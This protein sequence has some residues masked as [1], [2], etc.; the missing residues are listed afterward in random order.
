MKEHLV[1][2]RPRSLLVVW[3]LAR[4]VGR[5]RGRATRPPGRSRASSARATASPS[6]ASRSPST[7][8][9]ASVASTTGPD[10]TLPGRRARGRRVRRVGRRTRPRAA[11]ARDGHGRRRRAPARPR[12]RPG[13]RRR[14]RGRERHARRGDAL[15]A[16]RRAPTCSTASGSTTAPRPSL[17]PL[18]QEVPGVATARAGQT[19]LQALRVHPR[20]RV[21]LRVRARGRRAGQPAGRRLRL[22]HRAALRA[23]AGRGRARRGEQPLRQRRAGRRR[24][25][26]DAPRA[27]GRAP[28]APRRG[29]GRLLRLAALP[30]RD[31]GRA[32]RASTGTRAC[33]GS[34]TDN[35]EP[36]SRFEQ[37]AAALSA[38]REARRAHATLRAVVRFDDSTTGTPGPTA[39]G[40][41]D[42][43][44]SFER[45]DLVVSASR[46]PRR[47]PALS[48]QLSV[49]YARTDQLSL[50]P[51]RLR[52][53]DVPE[54]DGVDR[55]PSRSST[56]R[57]RR[58]SRTGRR[59]S[60]PATR[61][62]SRVGTRHLLTAGAEVEHETGELGNRAEELLR[63]G[64]HELR[65]STCRTACCSARA[66]T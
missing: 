45:Q 57:T 37:T 30:R 40:R 58:A 44:A 6:P 50:E 64:A 11:R 47:A 27:A 14:A 34:T 55:A 33:S 36:N 10:G 26:A 63:A 41:P 5:R 65:A 54:W 2:L 19:G 66:P 42:L 31:V 35:G 59:G 62:T 49:G 32:R 1:S 13:A 61:P 3:L 23:R 7:V 20:G 22:R 39:F 28:V 46:A 24:E 17:L 15:V 21:A 18:L 48:Q 9:P 52:P 53:L 60:P 43:D 38:G 8:R 16:R 29:R 51:A 4:R 25:P 56:S 12:P